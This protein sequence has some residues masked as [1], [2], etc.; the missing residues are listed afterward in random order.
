MTDQEVKT[1][2]E[3]VENTEATTEATEEVKEEA[4]NETAEETKE[5]EVPAEFKDIVEKIENLSV[6]ELHQLVKIFEEK[7]GVSA[8]AVAAAPAGGAGADGGAEQ[9]EFDVELTDVGGSK[10]GVIKA[11]KGALGLGLGDAKTMAESAPVVVKA[12]VSKED[13]EALKAELEAAG[14]S[15]ALK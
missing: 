10:I 11:L 15:V 12:G 6:I 7:F 14:A 5:V 13:A 9:T 4:T 1:T 8:A 3:V 2:E